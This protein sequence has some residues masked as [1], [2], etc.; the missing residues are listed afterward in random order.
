M[1]SP[2]TQHLVKKTETGFLFYYYKQC[3]NEYLCV[4]ICTWA[5]TFAYQ[6][7]CVLH[8]K[9]SAK[10]Y[11]KKVFPSPPFYQ[12]C[13]GVPVSCPLTNIKYIYS[14]IFTNVIGIISHYNFSLFLWLPMRF[15]IFSKG[16][17]LFVVILLWLLFASIC[18]FPFLFLVLF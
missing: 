17:G 5:V 9:K 13:M 14:L 7:V 8:F 3:Q 18:H 10:L 6:I 1:I 16:C 2:G 12:P 4:C 15:D 11:S